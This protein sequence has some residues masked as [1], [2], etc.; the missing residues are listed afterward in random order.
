V[1][2]ADVAVLVLLVIGAPAV[3]LHAFYRGRGDL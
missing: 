2:A 3:V 1:S